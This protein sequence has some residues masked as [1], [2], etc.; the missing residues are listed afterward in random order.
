M[1][2]PPPPHGHRSTSSRNTRR[3]CESPYPEVRELLSKALTADAA[4]EHVR[5]R[6]DPQTLT[7]DAVYSFCESLDGETRALGMKL[8]Q[9]NPRLAIPEELFRLT[10]SPDRQVR[11][12]VIKTI[13]S[14]YRDKGIT[15]QWKPG[16]PS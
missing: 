4:R 6:I 7:A 9:N 8:I 2:P 10:E 3:L 15:L 13:W 5:Y 14:L 12:F 1:D 11:A 16:G